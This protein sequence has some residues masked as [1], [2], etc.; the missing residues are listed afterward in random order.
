MLASASKDITIHNIIS[1]TEQDAEKLKQLE[2]KLD[3]K[4]KEIEKLKASGHA[5]EQN[6]LVAA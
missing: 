6:I 3:L 1:T 5:S 4:E 2:N